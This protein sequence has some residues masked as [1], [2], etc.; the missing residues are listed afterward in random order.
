[1]TYAQKRRATV[2]AIVQ[3]LTAVGLDQTVDGL[4]A[5]VESEVKSAFTRGVRAAKTKP[6]GPAKEKREAA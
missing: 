5:F 2:Q 3:S 6:E 4:A 1:M